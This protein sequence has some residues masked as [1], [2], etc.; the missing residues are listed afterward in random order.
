M[1]HTKAPEWAR[2]AVVVV[3]AL[4]IVAAMIVCACCG[5]ATEGTVFGSL[6]FVAVTVVKCA[7]GR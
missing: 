2:S 1:S 7:F 3:F 5:K 4:G 6:A